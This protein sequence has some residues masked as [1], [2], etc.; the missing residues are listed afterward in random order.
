VVEAQEHLKKETLVDW[1]FD[2]LGTMILGLILG[3]AAGSTITWRVM[4][5]RSTVKQQQRAGDKA[6]QVQIGR[7]TKGKP[8]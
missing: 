8:L 2:G 6:T 3:G 5:K 4:S 7:D 1:F